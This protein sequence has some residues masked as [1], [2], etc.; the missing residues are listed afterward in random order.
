MPLQRLLDQKFCDLIEGENQPHRGLIINM[1]RL[2]TRQLDCKHLYKSLCE[3]YLLFFKLDEKFDSHRRDCLDIN[4]NST[5]FSKN[6]NI[7]FKS[8]KI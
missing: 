1:V 5:E 8:I 4:E 3:N 7:E 6:K 2:F